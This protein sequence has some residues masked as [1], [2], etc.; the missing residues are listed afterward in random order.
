[1]DDFIRPPKKVEKKKD[2]RFVKETLIII[3]IVISLALGFVAGY[4]SKK[5]NVVHSTNKKGVV[6]EVYSTMKNNW[7]NAS[8]EKVDIETDGLKGF[9]DGLGDI[10]SSYFTSDE[11]SQFNESVGGNYQGIGVG[12]TMVSAGAMITKVYDHSPASE[13]DLKTGDI[14]VSANGHPLAGLDTDK[15]KEY[16]RGK[17]D[18]T[19]ELGIL[20]G[21]EQFTKTLTRKAVDTSVSYE[22]RNQGGKSF[23]YIQ[24]STFG[25]DTAN[26]VEEALKQFK[27]KNITSLVI[28]LRDNGGGYLNAAVNI[29]DL[30]LPS[31][32]CIYQM[33][34]KNSATKKYYAKTDH[35]YHF[36]YGYILVN[37]NTASASELTAGTLQNQ[38]GYK[39]IGTKTYGKG[40]AQTQLTLSDGSV[41]KYTYAKWMLPNGKC[42][43]GKGLTPDIKVD[44]A[45]LSNITIKKIKTPLQVDQV[46]S[47]VKSMQKMLKILGY[48]VDREDGYFSQASMSALQ[49]FEKDNNLTEDGTYS[50]DD[51]LMLIA[52]VMIYIQDQSHDQQYAR[53]LQEMQ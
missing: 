9:V 7:V 14:L 26:Q 20:R 51:K 43:H 49:Q 42:I 11:A 13:Q 50:E 40:T 37:E 21:K 29:L 25:T 4:F 44:N 47:S 18:T 16:V 32:K 5:T 28:D 10:H 52:R 12:Y 3:V 33:K 8:G 15:V 27:E 39:L 45:S 36:D 38:L 23:G 24:M 19:V 41:L 2:K 34:E 30:F 22:I 6:E 35:Y 31:D 1:M 53:L 46:S 48:Q 17:P